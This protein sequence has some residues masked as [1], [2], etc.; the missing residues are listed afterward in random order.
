L[1]RIMSSSLSWSDPGSSSSSM[2]TFVIHCILSGIIF[3]KVNISFFYP[4]Q[5]PSNMWWCKPKWHYNFVKGLSVVKSL[6]PSVQQEF[7]INQVFMLTLA[8]KGNTL[9]TWTMTILRNECPFSR[10]MDATNRPHN[11]I[12]FLCLMPL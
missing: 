2:L 3:R 9:W 8:L 10:W 12:T 1:L 6:P 7:T 11:I 4:L 5:R